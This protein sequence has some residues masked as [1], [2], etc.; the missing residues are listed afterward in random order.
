LCFS[1]TLGFGTTG[2]K[3]VI[4]NIISSA[5]SDSLVWSGR[6]LR[7]SFDA[8]VSGAWVL[9]RFIIGSFLVSHR[10]FLF[11]SIA[12]RQPYLMILGEFAKSKTVKICLFA[13]IRY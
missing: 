8:W 6:I 7:A 9:G 5:I 10:G 4:Q 13:I 11:A 1:I 3:R 12:G 2:G